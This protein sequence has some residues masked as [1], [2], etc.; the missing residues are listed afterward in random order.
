MKVFIIHGYQ[1]SPEQHWFPWLATKIEQMGSQCEIVHLQ[2]SDQPDFATWRQNLEAQVY[3]LNEQTI[4]VAHSLGCISVL[5]YLSEALNGRLIKAIFM[6]AGFNE[7]LTALPE[8][9]Q[10]VQQ[11]KLNDAL[12]RFRIQQRYSLFSCN[13]PF[14]PAPLSIR[15]GQLLNAQMIEVKKAGHFMQSDGLSEFPQ[16]W[17]KLEKLLVEQSVTQVVTI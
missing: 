5:D 2:G 17:E 13:D 6:V 7:K 15:F 1:S 3:P 11:A 10:F 9:N 16:L 12:L 14:V 4:I 8:L